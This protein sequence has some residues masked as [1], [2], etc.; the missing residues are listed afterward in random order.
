MNLADDAA[1]EVGKKIGYFID[2]HLRRR[3]ELLSFPFQD[4]PEMVAM[5][6]ESLVCAS[7]EVAAACSWLT[8]SS[9]S[10][11]GHLSSDVRFRGS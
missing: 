9:C 3:G 11:V 1:G 7:S 2:A 4:V 8:N 5:P 10:A 6:G